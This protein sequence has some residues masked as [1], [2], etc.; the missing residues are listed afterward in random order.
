V[1]R[2]GRDRHTAASARL[3]ARRQ[4]AAFA[5]VLGEAPA[6]FSRVVWEMVHAPM[7]TRLPRRDEPAPVAGE[8]VRP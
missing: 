6:R 8:I 2:R 3:L 5:H 4:V 1:R 7:W